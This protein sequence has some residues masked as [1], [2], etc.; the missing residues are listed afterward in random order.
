MHVADMALRVRTGQPPRRRFRFA[1]RF[2]EQL[3]DRVEMQLMGPKIHSP[4]IAS[5]DDRIQLQP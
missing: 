3:V 2:D 1:Q 4:S 5:G